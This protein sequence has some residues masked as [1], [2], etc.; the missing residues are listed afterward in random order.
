MKI[1]AKRGGKLRK[2]EKREAGAVGEMRIIKAERR[3][4]ADDGL[5][6]W[7]Y[8]VLLSFKLLV[9][10]TLPHKNPCTHSLTHA[11]S[12]SPSCLC[13]ICSSWCTSAREK[14]TPPLP[15]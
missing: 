10:N 6:L 1:K 8:T 15:R 5:I 13:N 9:F 14:P 11:L 3:I 4:N 7:S 2:K 12:L